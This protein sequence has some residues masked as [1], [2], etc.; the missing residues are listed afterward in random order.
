METQSCKFVSPNEIFKFIFS[1]KHSYR[2]KAANLKI[3]MQKTELKNLLFST[4]Y[5]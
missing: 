3:G 1:K 5:L 4:R 2:L